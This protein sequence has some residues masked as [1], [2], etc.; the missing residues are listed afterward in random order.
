MD[1]ARHSP[2]SGT[3]RGAWELFGTEYRNAE[4]GVIL[5]GDGDALVR[6]HRVRVSLAL[7]E[8]PEALVQVDYADHVGNAAG[9]E[10]LPV[11][12]DHGE[13]V[14]R[15]AAGRVAPLRLA[16]GAAGAVPARVED[17]LAALRADLVGQPVAGGRR[18]ERLG[19]GLGEQRQP[20]LRQRRSPL[21]LVVSGSLTGPAD[22]ARR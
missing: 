11:L 9:Q 3:L 7:R 10:R 22:H 6:V 19:V 1:A 12:A 8:H 4:P 17:H 14:H 13:R 5:P 20:A 21:L 16:P 15:A 18:P 2:V